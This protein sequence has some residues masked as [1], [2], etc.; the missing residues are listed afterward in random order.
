MKKIKRPGVGPLLTRRLLSLTVF[1]PPFVGEDAEENLVHPASV[2]EDLLAQTAGLAIAARV[3][4]DYP[5]V[6]RSIHAGDLVADGA[7]RSQLARD[8]ADL[9]DLV[10]E[11]SPAPIKATSLM[12]RVFAGKVSFSGA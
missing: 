1:S 4:N 12:Q 5:T 3:A 7:S 2:S 8:L 9:A 6:D 11:P 10:S